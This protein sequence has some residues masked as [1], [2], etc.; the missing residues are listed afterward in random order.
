MALLRDPGA[1]L[2]GMTWTTGRQPASSKEPP[3]ISRRGPGWGEASGKCGFSTSSKTP[4]RTREASEGGHFC[5]PP[6]REKFYM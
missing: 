5:C 1:G 4:T 6:P 3:R 2:A